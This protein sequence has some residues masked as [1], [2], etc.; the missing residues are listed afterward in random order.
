MPHTECPESKRRSGTLPAMAVRRDW[1]WLEIPLLVGVLVGGAVLR[2]W[3]STVV[4]FDAAEME[5]LSEASVRSH[6][7]RTPFIMF[8]GL[9]LFM[10]YIIA[11][12]SAGVPAAF[13]LIFLLQT[14]I[15]FQQQALR[16]RWSSVAVFVVLTAAAYVRMSWPAWRPSRRVDIGLMVIIAVFAARGVQ[17]VVTLPGRLDSIRESTF[18]DSSTFYDSLVEC[19]GSRVTPLEVL[20]R[21]EL[22]WPAGRSLQQQ[23]AL[24]VHSQNLSGH[25]TLLDGPGP[26]PAVDHSH[27]AVFDAEGVGL[28]VVA[29]GEMVATTQRVL[30]IAR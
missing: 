13:A 14:S 30:G 3:L 18:A 12:R 9:S 7:V 17:L 1:A 27:V 8:N 19:G 25:A 16:I 29:E 10:F 23:E 26:V 11:R 15:P 4:P 2:Y 22:D 20:T 24:L 28:F 21:C 6:A 5:G